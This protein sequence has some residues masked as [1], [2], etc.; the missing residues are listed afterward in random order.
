MNKIK[1]ERKVNTNR[2]NNTIT[3]DI[4]NLSEISATVYTIVSA[5]RFTQRD[6]LHPRHLV[7]HHHF[8]PIL[9]VPCKDLGVGDA[10]SRVVPHHI[11]RAVI[12]PSDQSTLVI[13]LRNE[14]SFG[15]TDV[16]Q[17]R[18]RHTLDNVPQSDVVRRKI[19]KKAG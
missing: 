9:S 11:H 19:L 16:F 6:T 10:V 12:A 4:H 18:Q 7:H 15:E 2:I 3:R 17:E 8:T 13:N 14:R 1:K 5:E